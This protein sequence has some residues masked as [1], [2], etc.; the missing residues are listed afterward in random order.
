MNHMYDT[1]YNIWPRQQ[2]PGAHL[3]GKGMGAAEKRLVGEA[4]M[5]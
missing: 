4:K 5:N 1:A 2:A 3:L